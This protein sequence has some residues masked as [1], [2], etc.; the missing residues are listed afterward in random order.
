[1]VCKLA[2]RRDTPCFHSPWLGLACRYGNANELAE[3]LCVRG[4]EAGAIAAADLARIAHAR[5]PLIQHLGGA[6]LF[7]ELSNEILHRGNEARFSIVVVPLEPSFNFHMLVDSAILY[8]ARLYGNMS[9]AIQAAVAARRCVMFG[10]RVYSVVRPE[11]CVWVSPTQARNDAGCAASTPLTG[12]GLRR[13]RGTR[14]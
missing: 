14:R 5:T 1:M 10:L 11:P 9:F 8:I 12:D 2:I 7:T 13:N 4:E 3:S 6:D